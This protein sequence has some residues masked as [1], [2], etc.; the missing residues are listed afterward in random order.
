MTRLLRGVRPWVVVTAVIALFV[1]GVIV[2]FNQ[3]FAAGNV[4]PEYSSMRTDRMGAK[5]LYDSLGRLPGV[6]VE[7]NFG[8]F[9]F[10]PRSGATV[11]MLAYDPLQAN[12]GAMQFLRPVEAMASRGN[13]VVVTMRV[14]PYTTPKEE[15]F[16]KQSDQNPL[17]LKKK[18]NKD[19]PPPDPPLYQKWKVKFGYKPGKDV[20][21]PLYFAEAE[22]WTVLDRAGDRT[23]AIE[24]NFGQGSVV[25]MAESSDFNNEN[26]VGMQRLRQVTL[27]LG[28]NHRIV[29]DEQH[30][31]IEESGTIVGMARRFRLSGIA[32]GLGL[33]AALFIWRN[34]S[35]FPP[36]SAARP[37]NHY[38]GR[39]SHAGLLTLLR[40]H[41][42][43]AELAAVCWR[44]WL[45]TNRHEVTP[46]RLKKATAILD[47]PG[48]P[49][50]KTREIQT[51]LH[52]KG[53]L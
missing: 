37:G 16:T 35:S 32:I 19:E 52:A 15:D 25:L 29:F 49:L 1:G 26:V 22:G 34:S 44:E 48:L 41:I 27:A 43:P 11:L 21:H 4:Y 18:E 40:R 31:G 30:L 51:V 45:S 28:P 14:Q 46:E 6:T 47:R 38:S 3:Q 13:R 2:L 5:L 7:R 10:L 42:P 8:P 24:R 53:E 36:P 50:E 20:E 23:L 9:E 17:H 39:T 33:V 12:W